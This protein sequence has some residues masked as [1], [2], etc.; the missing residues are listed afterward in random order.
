M[1]VVRTNVGRLNGEIELQSEPG[2]GTRI[3]IKLP[4][5]VIVSDALLVRAGGETF[6]VPMHAIRS[7][8]QVRP[9]DIIRADDR[10]RVAVEDEEVELV[11]LE[12]ALALPDGRPL[13]RLPVLVVRSGVRPL[14]VAVEELVGKEDVVIKN[15][16]GL[17]ERVGPFAG[18]TITG[19]GRVI[20]L[21]DPSRLAEA[22]TVSPRPAQT[23]ASS[24]ASAPPRSR[25]V[26][27]VDDSISVR[28]FVGHM[29]EKA[30]FEVLTA[31]DGAEALRRLVDTTVET[32][33]TDLEMPRVSGYEL[34]EDLRSRP[35]M[36]AIPVVV[37]TTRAGAKH[38]GLARRLG[39]AHYVTKPVDEEA[40]VRL[41]RRVIARGAGIEATE[42]VS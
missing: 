14:A 6:A 32:V 29:L 35:S 22:R 5:T 10:E 16:G 19:D 26:L 34:I 42:T 13:A 31:A 8:I 28:R 40:F 37:L 11:R 30:G 1:D 17:L 41:I 9:E 15:L 2:A 18:A 36:R 23:T 21:V 20:L 4:L 24:R 33:I 3:T 25:R 27:L 39:I 38:V 7:I 12:R